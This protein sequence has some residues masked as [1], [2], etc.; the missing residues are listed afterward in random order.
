METFCRRSYI[1]VDEYKRI[2]NFTNDHILTI[3]FAEW[4]NSELIGLATFPWEKEVYSIYGGIIMQPKRF[5]TKGHRDNLV[6]EIG[7]VLGLWHVHHGVSESSCEDE[8]REV[9]PSM[10]TG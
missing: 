9:V 3:T 1:G 2:L 8:C 6:H 5:G 7:H 10:L 4:S